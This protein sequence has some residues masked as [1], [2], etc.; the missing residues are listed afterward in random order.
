M[1]RRLCLLELLAEENREGDAVLDEARLRRG[2]VASLFSQ[3]ASGSPK[4]LE[5][6]N[7][8]REESFSGMRWAATMAM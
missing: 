1:M 3:T 2:I 8:F 5:R 7:E 6:T 4:K